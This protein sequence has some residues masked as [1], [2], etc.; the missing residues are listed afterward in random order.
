MNLQETLKARGDLSIIVTDSSGAIKQAV[1]IPNLVVTAG[2]NYIASRMAAN[3]TTIMSHMSI[4][5]GVAA[6][7]A[8]NQALGTELGREALTSFTAAANVVTATAT[9]P[10]GSGT[11][12]ITEAGIFNTAT[13]GDG[14]LTKAMLCRTTFPVVNKQ[15]GDT[16]AIT[17]NI[18][19]S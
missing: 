4:G 13:G 6:P 11:G 16:I 12:A 19:I 17:W 10:P 15:A 9:F 3:T 7:D 18:T 1:R 8:A 14:S 2:K 5:A